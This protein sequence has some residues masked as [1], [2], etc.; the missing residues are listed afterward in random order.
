MDH[1]VHWRIP[2]AL[3]RSKWPTEPTCFRHPCTVI[4]D[5]YLRGFFWY[6]RGPRSTLTQS[7]GRS[8]IYIFDL[9]SKHSTNIETTHRGNGSTLNLVEQSIY[10]QLYFNLLRVF[11][12]M[13]DH[14]VLWRIPVA[15][16]HSKW[17]RPARFSYYAVSLFLGLGNLIFANAQ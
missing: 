15:L 14:E 16:R 4:F 5:L 10:A 7:C 6:H 12:T 1:E 3:R 11:A 8:K 2:V 17:R 13:V 9:L